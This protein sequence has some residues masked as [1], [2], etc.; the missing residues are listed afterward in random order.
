M[1][2]VH[3]IK[4]MKKIKVKLDDIDYELKV[5]SMDQLKPLFSM[6]QDNPIEVMEAQRCLLTGMGLSDDV[7]KSLGFYEAQQLMEIVTGE[8]KKS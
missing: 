2:E 1:S 8:V 6:K 5:P 3:V 7:V 4:R